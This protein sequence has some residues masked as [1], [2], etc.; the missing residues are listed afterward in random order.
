VQT[1]KEFDG[2]DVI[3]VIDDIDGIDVEMRATPYHPAREEGSGSSKTLD[4]K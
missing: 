1:G 2:I 4:H 3:D